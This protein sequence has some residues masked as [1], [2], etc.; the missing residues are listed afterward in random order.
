MGG[1]VG[2]LHEPDVVMENC[3]NTGDLAA[4][5]GNADE[6]YATDGAEVWEEWEDAH[7]RTY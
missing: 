3:E 6:L 2:Y 7:P 1:I 4:T 5:N